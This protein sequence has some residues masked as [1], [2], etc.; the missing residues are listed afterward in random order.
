MK[1]AHTRLTQH[2]HLGVRGVVG[3]GNNESITTIANVETILAKPKS[4]VRQV[5]QV[6]TVFYYY[7]PLK[8]LRFAYTHVHASEIENLGL[9]SFEKSALLIYFAVAK[10]INIVN[11]GQRYKFYRTAA[12]NSAVKIT[13]QG[14]NSPYEPQN[15]GRTVRENV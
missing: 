3:V 4:L 10:L 6:N 7:C 9:I 13:R 2:T 12:T 1:T 8:L 11:H 14:Q 5:L 15:G